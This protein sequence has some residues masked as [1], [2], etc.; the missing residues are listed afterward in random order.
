MAGHGFSGN[1]GTRHAHF[2]IM[3]AAIIDK[4]DR[5]TGVSNAVDRHT[6]LDLFGA[7]SRYSDAVERVPEAVVQ[8][9]LRP[10]GGKA[11]LESQPAALE[12]ESQQRLQDQ[13]IHPA[14]RA[15]V[16][17]PAAA[18]GVRRDGVDVGGDDVRLDLVGRD[19]LPR[20]S[21]G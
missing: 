18:A 6:R 10:L 16:P 20:I 14:G 11:W 3:L 8:L 4:R 9:E 17:G 12:P 2:D 19:R 13:A 21:R 5:S 7:R 1:G 15:R